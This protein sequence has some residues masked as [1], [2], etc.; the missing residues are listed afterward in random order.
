MECAPFL[1]RLRQGALEV[2]WVQ[3]WVSVLL[4]MASRCERPCHSTG[5]P[6]AQRVSFFLNFPVLCTRGKY[7]ADKTQREKLCTK[8]AGSHGSVL[9]GLFTIHCC[10]HTYPPT[11]S[12]IYTTTNINLTSNYSIMAIIK[13][14]V[15]SIWSL[16]PPKSWC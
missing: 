10:H 9:P 8:N 5:L 7:P 13:F 15:V 3:D 2:S 12:T 4:K 6:S 14:S 11:H 1:T 16:I